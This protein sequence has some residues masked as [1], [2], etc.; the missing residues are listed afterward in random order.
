MTPDALPKLR[1]H[2]RLPALLLLRRPEVAPRGA[3]PGLRRVKPTREP[4]PPPSGSTAM[5]GRTRH[6]H[7]PRGL[8]LKRAV[9]RQGLSRSG[10]D[11]E[12]SSGILDDCGRLRASVHNLVGHCCL[13]REMR[14]NPDP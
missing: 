9:N 4:A 13:P 8:H 11:S 2:L 10:R 7:Y 5:H 1:L 12:L 14:R 3:A 6:T